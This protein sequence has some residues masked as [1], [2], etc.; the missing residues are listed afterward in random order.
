MIPYLINLLKD[1]P[2]EIGAP[3]ATPYPDNLFKVITVGE[4]RFLP[5]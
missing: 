2:E 5:E 3:T 1:F 4:A